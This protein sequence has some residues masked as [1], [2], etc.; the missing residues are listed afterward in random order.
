[1]E[2]LSIL[3]VIAGLSFLILV[4]P[5]ALDKIKPNRFYGVRLKATL[6]DESLWY[7]TNRYFGRVG[8]ISGV[9]YFV[10]SLSFGLWKAES[11]NLSIN[12]L[13]LIMTIAVPIV[14]TQFKLS[15]M[16]KNK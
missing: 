6:S 2:S 5:L 7:V 15:K 14:V 8:V 1:M 16:T 12:S 10:I 3:F 13:L 4:I 11:F 9:I